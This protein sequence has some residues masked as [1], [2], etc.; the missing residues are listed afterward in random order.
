MSNYKIRLKRKNK[1]KNHTI[2]TAVKRKY[3]EIDSSSNEEQKRPNRKLCLD[4]FITQKMN[5]EEEK[6]MIFVN[7]F[8]DVLLSR[9]SAACVKMKMNTINSNNI[10][11]REVSYIF[12]TTLNKCRDICASF[13]GIN[14]Y[15]GIYTCLFLALSYGNK[16]K[17]R[18]GDDAN[19][20]HIVFNVLNQMIKLFKPDVNK[21]YNLGSHILTIYDVVSY[22]LKQE[23]ITKMFH[24]YIRP[25]LCS[26]IGPKSSGGV[27][28]SEIESDQIDDGIGKIGGSHETIVDEDDIFSLS[29]FVV[30]PPVSAATSLITEDKSSS[31]SQH[32]RS[33]LIP[34]AV[35]ESTP[36][37]GKFHF[38]PPSPFHKE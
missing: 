15:D 14:I 33:M 18:K 11:C 30:S 32:E 1:M 2:N 29:E 7:C 38:I 22:F 25:P 27:E 34:T 4:L 6:R 19:I 16:Q 24:G 23:I 35:R 8:H 13:D 37:K 3:S 5:E 20:V 28:H 36:P 10:V 21:Q 9:A 12:Q 31:F 17:I 26:S